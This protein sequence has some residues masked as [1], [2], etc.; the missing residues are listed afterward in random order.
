M[1]REAK[2]RYNEF[3]GRYDQVLVQVIYV[4]IR[5]FFKYLVC[6]ITEAVFKKDDYHEFFTMSLKY[7]TTNF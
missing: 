5:S 4:V 6:N 2:T 1:L 3:I 7:F